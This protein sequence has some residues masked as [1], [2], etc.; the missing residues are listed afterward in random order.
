MSGFYNGFSGL[1]FNRY[2]NLDGV[3]WRIIQF[4]VD[5]ESKHAQ[6]LWK[7]LKYADENCLF[8]P[9]LTRKEKL[10][11]IYRDTGLSTP[12][13]VFMMPYVDDAWEEQASRLDV[14]VESIT[15]INQVTS[16]VNIGIEVLTHNKIGNIWGEAEEGVPATNPSEIDDEG[17]I[18]V[19]SKS[20]ST[21]MLKCI[22]AELNGREVAAV[23]QLQCNSQVDANCK[24]TSKVWNNR[25]YYGYQVI[26]SVIMSGVSSD[27]SIGY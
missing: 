2:T 26:F 22:L 20:R 17:N 14:Y 1:D 19:P 4:L 3:E 12:K 24:V 11:L 15:P 23:G 13:R 21:T 10:G 25:A 16:R 6:M 18:L 9:D 27:S 8:Q 7:M 5:S